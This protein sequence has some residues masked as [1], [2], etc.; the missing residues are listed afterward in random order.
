MDMKRCELSRKASVQVGDERNPQLGPV[1][2]LTGTSA[3]FPVDTGSAP[4]ALWSH[5]TRSSLQ[6]FSE[7][8]EKVWKFSESCKIR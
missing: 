2:T 7:S 1:W 4:A 5:W 8:L 3:V 6:D